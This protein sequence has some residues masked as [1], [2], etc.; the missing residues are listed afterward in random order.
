MCVHAEKQRAIDF[1]PI[2]V[3]ANGLTDG[4]YMPDVPNA[5][6][7]AETFGSGTSV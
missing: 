7:C 5:T 1:L 6:R 2:A 4:E 3:K